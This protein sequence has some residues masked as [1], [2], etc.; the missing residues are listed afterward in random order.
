MSSEINN[1]TPFGKGLS[2][3]ENLLE[4]IEQWILPLY[5]DANPAISN[6]DATNGASINDVPALVSSASDKEDKADDAHAAGDHQT[7][8]DLLNS[9]ADDHVKAV[10]AFK[11]NGDGDK[12]GFHAGEVGRLR[13]KA[14]DIEEERN[15]SGD[16]ASEINKGG[17]GS[18]PQWNHPFRG[19]RFTSVPEMADKYETRRGTEN[20]DH[21]QH[22]DAAKA[23]IAAANA[24]ARAGHFNE[25]ASHLHEAAYHQTRA[26]E[27]VQKPRSE[28]PFVNRRFGEKIVSAHESAHSAEGAARDASIAQGKLLKATAGGADARTLAGLRTDAAQKMDLATKSLAEVNAVQG[29]L[30][31]ARVNA[32]D[33]TLN[34][35]TA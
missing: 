33:P 22:L 14:Q 23:H 24:A 26:A 19:N 12:I 8:I 25:A 3:S 35:Q 31:S 16:I 20:F 5:K 4:T 10:G 27:L 18:G 29:S 11:R 6:D 2:M 32:S 21:G 34:R 7:A 30:D 15:A 17:P 9:A 1:T 28:Y 13:G